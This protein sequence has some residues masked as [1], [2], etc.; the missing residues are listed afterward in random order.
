MAQTSFTR[1]INLKQIG[2]GL[3]SGTWGLS[4][5]ENWAR[6]EAHL[7]GSTIVDFSSPPTGS[8]YS[9]HTL[10]WLLKDSSDADQSGGEGRYG[11]VIFVDGATDLGDDQTVDIYGNTTGIRPDRIFIAV[12]A[13]TGGHSIIFSMGGDEVTLKNGK[14]AIIFTRN[15]A[16]V[17][18]GTVTQIAANSVNPID[19]LQLP[20]LDV[21]SITDLSSIVAP[22]AGSFSLDL[23]AVASASSTVSIKDVDAASL[24]FKE[25]TNSYLRFDTEHKK[26]AIGQE[27]SDCEILRVDTGRIDVE[28]QD[29]TLQIIADKNLALLIGPS[30]NMMMRFD[31]GVGEDKLRILPGTGERPYTFTVECDATFT[32]GGKKTTIADAV[33]TTADINGGTI[34]GSALNNCTIGNATAALGEFTGIRV[35]ASGY[36]NFGATKLASGYGIRDN[37][38]NV[39]E[40][41]NNAVPYNY[42]TPITSI[43]PP[44]YISGFITSNDTD[45]LIHDITVTAGHCIDSTNSTTMVGPAYTK[46]INSAW[47]SGNDQGGYGADE[48]LAADTWYRFFVISDA[49]GTN[50]DYGWDAVDQP[51]AASL[52]DDATT[53]H[54][55]VTYTLYRQIAWH[56]TTDAV[57]PFALKA[58]IQTANVPNDFVWT[59]DE[60]ELATGDTLLPGQTSMLDSLMPLLF[61][62]KDCDSIVTLFITPQTQD[63]NVSRLVKLNDPSMGPGISI[64]RNN[65]TALLYHER[66]NE[67]DGNNGAVG[68]RVPTGWSGSVS[69]IW[70]K[71]QTDPGPDVGPSPGATGNVFIYVNAHG[72]VYGRGA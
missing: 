58:Y 62:P 16:L 48:G 47:A 46:Q 34:D 56:R 2:T 26:L 45:D 49:D 41:K 60:K 36:A 10:T 40:I 68:F 71:V 33:L 65:A 29:T 38:P 67:V 35:D 66:Q 23:S 52:L 13:L 19:K 30:G 72:F 39:I 27:T 6:V 11:V 5:N 3:E 7:G 64:T 31:T 17:D 51:A 9:P 20:S 15:V 44:N 32:S 59:E 8:S 70:I 12:N 28:N 42:W 55:G 18:S 24:D 21:A 43:L 57:S 53:A 54:A 63:G 61:V 14:S 50:V 1:G 4:T 37:G 22:T 69:Q 25:G